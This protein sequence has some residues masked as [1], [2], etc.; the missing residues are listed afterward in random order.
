MKPEGIDLDIHIN[1]ND[2]IR[3]SEAR[4]GKFDAAELFAR[5]FIADIPFM[6]RLV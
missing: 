4:A 6:E 2:R 1:S 3:Q 5:I